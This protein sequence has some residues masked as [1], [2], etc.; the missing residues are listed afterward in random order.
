MRSWLYCLREL[1]DDKL[2]LQGSAPSGFI[3]H[4]APHT[5]PSYT[6]LP[7][8]ALTAICSGSSTLLG[9]IYGGMYRGLYRI[10]WVCYRYLL[11]WK[12]IQEVY[13]KKSDFLYKVDSLLRLAADKHSKCW[14]ETWKLKVNPTKTKTK[15][16]TVRQTA[17]TDDHNHKHSYTLEHTRRTTEIYKVFTWDQTFMDPTYTTTR[18]KGGV[19]GTRASV[20]PD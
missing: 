17:T 20:P 7:P 5:A 11:G 3:R 19:P 8:R 1:V 18:T 9:S 14:Y 10:L 12:K 13:S 15:I 2:F 6:Y 4:L 16:F